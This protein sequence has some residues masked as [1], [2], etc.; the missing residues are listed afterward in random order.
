ML[1]KKTCKTIAPVLYQ[2]FKKIL[3]ERRIPS[4]NLLSLISPLLKPGKDASKPSSYR[5]IALT[6]LWIRLLEKILKKELQWHAER[7]G[8]LSKDQH[9]FCCKIQPP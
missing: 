4:I 9:G 8:L 7:L 1:A 2:L 3:K 5:P 6:E